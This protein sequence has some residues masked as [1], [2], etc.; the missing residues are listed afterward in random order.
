MGGWLCHNKG[1]RP[2]LLGFFLHKSPNANSLFEK[3]GKTLS[4]GEEQYA[5]GDVCMFEHIHLRVNICPV[6]PCVSHECLCAC[7]MSHTYSGLHMCACVPEKPEQSMPERMK[8]PLAL[9]EK[10]NRVCP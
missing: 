1:G 7:C 8:S 2:K 3:R 10:G 5:N 9:K 4:L 6:F